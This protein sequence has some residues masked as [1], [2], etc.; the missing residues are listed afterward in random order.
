MQDSLPGAVQKSIGFQASPNSKP[1]ADEGLQ[2]CDS[3]AS[4]KFCLGGQALTTK[5]SRAAC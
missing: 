4:P 5:K 1:R 2:L 3:A